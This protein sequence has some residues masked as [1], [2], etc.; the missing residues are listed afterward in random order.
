MDHAAIVAPVIPAPAGDGARARKGKPTCG[1]LSSRRGALSASSPPRAVLSIDS[2]AHEIETPSKPVKKKRADRRGARGLRPYNLGQR[3]PRPAVSRLPRRPEDD[4]SPDGS[5]RP[6]CSEEIRSFSKIRAPL[7]AAARCG[8][9][10]PRCSFTTLSGARIAARYHRRW[11][12]EP[13]FD[14]VKTGMLE[15]KKRS[16][17]SLRAALWLPG[18]ISRFFLPERR[19]MRTDP[20]RGPHQDERLPARAAARAETA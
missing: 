8:S 7:R 6:G 17:A 9:S 5:G 19:P 1:I 15:A 18:D 13:G 3:N 11:E 16:A 10:S 2:A 12:L 20:Q 14:E 4:R